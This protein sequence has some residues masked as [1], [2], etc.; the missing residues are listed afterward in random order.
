ME[1]RRKCKDA[2]SDEERA[3]SGRVL[4]EE[5]MGKMKGKRSGRSGRGK[6]PDLQ[7]KE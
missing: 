1:R 2:C 7:V 6:V 3:R 4:C 5:V